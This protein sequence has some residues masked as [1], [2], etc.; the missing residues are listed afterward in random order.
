MCTQAAA[1]INI[2]NTIDA[3][4]SWRTQ[5]RAPSCAHRRHRAR[6]G[7]AIHAVIFQ[8]AR[9]DP[10]QNPTFLRVL[11]SR[12]LPAFSTKAWEVGSAVVTLI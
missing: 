9:G 6:A 10:N 5:R 3:P 12:A 2:I 7:Q 11:G 4:A 8:V 1:S